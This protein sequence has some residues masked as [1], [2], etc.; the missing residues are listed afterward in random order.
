MTTITVIG[1]GAIGASLAACLTEA[2]RPVTLCGRTRRHEIEV[3]SDDGG[4]TVIPGV[5][6]TD[7]SAVDGPV[8]VILLAVKGTQVAAARPWLAP[9]RHAS[10][11]RLT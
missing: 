5:V 8:D 4:S 9:T 2:G 10:R 11:A 6:H 3:R 7:P 1:P